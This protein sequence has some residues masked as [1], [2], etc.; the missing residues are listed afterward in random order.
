MYSQLYDPPGA[1]SLNTPPLDHRVCLHHPEPSIHKAIPDRAA[2]ID[3]K[4]HGFHDRSN[5]DRGLQCLCT[6]QS[7]R[8]NSRLRHFAVLGSILCRS[9]IPSATVAP[10]KSQERIR[11]PHAAVQWYGADYNN[12]TGWELERKNFSEPKPEKRGSCR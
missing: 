7:T 2:K 4:V 3:G 10:K 6:P 5:L 1:A 8:K 9:N 11:N 12:Q